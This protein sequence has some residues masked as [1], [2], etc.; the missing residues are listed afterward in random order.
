MAYTSN[1]DEFKEWITTRYP[2]QKEYLQATLDIAKDVIPICNANEKYKQ[3]DVFKRLCEPERTIQFCVTWLNDANEIQIN[4]GWR[5][6]HCGLIGPYKGGLRFHPTVNES[7][8]KFLAFEQSFKNA[9]TGLPIGGAKGGSDFNPKGRS[10]YEVM[11]FCQA[12]MQELQRHIGPYT[13][14][15]AGDINVGSREIGF[16]YGEYRKINNRFGGAITG[17][18]IEFGGSYVRTEATGFGL[19]Y[20][21]DDVLEHTGTNIKGK[22]IAVSG[23]GNVALHAALKATQ[24]GGK[25]VTLSNSRG[26]LIHEKGFTEE[27]LNWVINH[28]GEPDN[29]L[30]SLN[31]RID[32]DWK[33]DEKPWQTEVDIALP[34]ATQ[35]ELIGKDARALISNGCK[36]VLEGANMPCNDAAQ[37][38]FSDAKVV[39]VPGKASNAGGVA[40]S[41]LEMS[42]NAT[43]HKATYKA[44]NS[45]LKEIMANIHRQCVE[46]GDEGDYVNYAKGANV[47]AFRRLADALVA[48]GV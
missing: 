15:P 17:K 41:G 30:L 24:H 4:K 33:A 13:D 44:M 20:F 3:W 37:R 43:F 25:V 1:L 46:E 38:A 48:Q 35:N 12:F 19:I 42:Q 5:V 8:L 18:D 21:L 9:L 2:D 26:T 39:F 28:K 16:L 7:I 34:C 36:F 14:V 10:D 32:G 40:L 31:E 23:A 27:D 47:A 6:Q 22:R 45:A 11:R 29:I